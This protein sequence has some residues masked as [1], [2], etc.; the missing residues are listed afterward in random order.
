MKY[1]HQIIIHKALCKIIDNS[2]SLV[3]FTVWGKSESRGYRLFRVK[4]V[5]IHSDTMTH[6]I[7]IYV[8]I[9]YSDIVCHCINIYVYICFSRNN[10]YPLLSLLPHNVQD[11]KLQLLSIIVHSVV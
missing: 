9:I 7:T 11:T 2:W 8:H 10:L 5:N 1:K 3:C 6:C 4:H